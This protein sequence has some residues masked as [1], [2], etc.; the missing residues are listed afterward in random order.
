M[1]IPKIN[2]RRRPAKK[3]IAVSGDDERKFRMTAIRQNEQAHIERVIFS[4]A[5][6]P[7]KG[8]D[9]LGARQAEIERHF[10]RLRSC[11]FHFSRGVDFGAV[12]L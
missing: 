12:D 9:L 5:P 6:D 7:L 1:V 3:L 10:A 4:E 11:C 2:G 8:G